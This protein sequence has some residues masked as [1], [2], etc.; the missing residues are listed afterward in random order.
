MAYL[1]AFQYVL[2]VTVPVFLIVFLGAFLK[3]RKVIDAGFVE[4]ASNLVFK[5]CL[6]VL[7]FLSILNNNVDLSVYGELVV[8]CL[9][10]AA[11]AFL[12]IWKFSALW[13]PQKDRGV[14]VQGAFRSNLGIIGLALCAKAFESD[15]LA[16]GAVI[17]A[18]VTPLY[19]VLSIYALSVSQYG[20]ANLSMGKVLLDV[21]KNPLI[22]A[23]LLGFAV[24]GLNLSLPQMVE[25]TA[26]YLAAMT[27]PLALI[28]IGGALS[29][30]ELKSTSG[31][32]LQVVFV[33]LILL[34]ITVLIMA[35]GLG[36]TGVELGCILLMFASP[37]ATASFIMVRA[38]GG[39]YSLASNIIVI[40]TLLSALSVSLLLYAAKV[41]L[42]I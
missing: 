7:L 35:K 22:V 10:A 30:S 25:D 31:L 6:P 11:V 37:T 2:S 19:N 18:V 14:V 16:V 15:G 3:Y 40:S 1:D 36:F 21:L 28:S 12:V 24:A 39:N 42:W 13:V 26:G 41:W 8:F 20:K 38:M 23:I 32:S 34:P 33:K 27:L 9:G 17:L 29:V 5:V 4:T